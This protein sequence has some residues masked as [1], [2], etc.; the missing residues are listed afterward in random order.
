[1]SAPP[2]LLTYTALLLR[3]EAEFW[4]VALLRAFVGG[5]VGYQGLNRGAYSKMIPR[6]RE[7]EFF[8][9][10]LVAVK[11]TAWTA[12][13][14]FSITNQ[15]TRSMRAATLSHLLFYV[16]ALVVHFFTDFDIAMEEA[17]AAAP[18]CT[19]ADDEAKPAQQEHSDA[20]RTRG[21]R[22]PGVRKLPGTHRDALDPAA[23]ESRQ[24]MGRAM[25]SIRHLRR[26]ETRSPR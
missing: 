6:G 12:P 26:T 10:W 16:P 7:A 11:G 13:L 21:A 9:F 15:V 2:L 22:S 5:A 25:R 14:L 8:G 18:L 4:V 19:P 24:S 20:S 23:C 3:T 17:A 1:M